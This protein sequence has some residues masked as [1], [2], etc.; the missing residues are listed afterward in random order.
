MKM[1]GDIHGVQVIIMID[2]GAT[3]KFISLTTGQKLNLPISNHTKSRVILGNGE[4]IQGEVECG[5]IC[6]EVQGLT[7]CEDFL[8][9]ELGGSD[10]ILGLQWLEKLGEIITNW[11][12]QVM[13]F[14]WK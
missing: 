13:L 8:I 10:V 11:K 9:L 3:N 12:E 5:Q 7:I 14:N 2:P 1:K 6:I 4:R